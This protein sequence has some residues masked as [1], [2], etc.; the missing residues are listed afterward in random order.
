MATFSNTVMSG[1]IFTCWKVRA[2]PRR[3]I[4]REGRPLM[5][6][7]RNCTAPEVSG[8]TP[9]MRLKVV[10]LPAPLGPIRPT[11]WPAWI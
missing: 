3:K 7:P 2:M 11:I 9:V 1:I 8:S 4:S 10:D 6:S 5:V